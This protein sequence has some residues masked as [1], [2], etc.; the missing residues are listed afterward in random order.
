LVVVLVGIVLVD[1]LLG[2]GVVGGRQHLIM[3]LGIV[4]TEI[5]LVK[6]LVGG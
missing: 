3:V 4:L 1:I 2:T 6:E 5:L